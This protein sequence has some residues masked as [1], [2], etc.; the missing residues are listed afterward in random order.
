MTKNDQLFCFVFFIFNRRPTKDGIVGWN[1]GE[2]LPLTFNY[3]RATP[4]TS[5]SFIYK[6]FNCMA[7]DLAV[8]MYTHCFGYTF[9]IG[10]F[11]LRILLAKSLTV[12]LLLF[13]GY[14]FLPVLDQCPHVINETRVIVETVCLLLTLKYMGHRLSL[15]MFD[16]EQEEKSCFD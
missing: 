12:L 7:S 8:G 1:Y 3:F 2:V 10:N 9:L 16:I 14:S 13:Q 11:I 15:L 5:A 4:G 6:L